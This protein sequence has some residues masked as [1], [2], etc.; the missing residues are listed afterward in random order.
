[1]VP[2]GRE[3]VGK[4]TSIDLFL[5]VQKN[6]GM[7]PIRALKKKCQDRL[8]SVK[9]QNDSAKKKVIQKNAEDLKKFKETLQKAID[10]ELWRRTKRFLHEN[11]R[12]RAG[13]DVWSIKLDELS[14]AVQLFGCGDVP[15]DFSMKTNE[16]ELVRMS[17][18]SSW[19]N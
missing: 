14:E 3:R 11:K 15:N 9:D 2:T 19:M 4:H 18:A 13:E 7:R 17:G 8:E 12:A 1:M 10:P 6:D 16:L 5:S